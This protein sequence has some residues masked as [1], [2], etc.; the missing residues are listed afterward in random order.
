MKTLGAICSNRSTTLR[1]PKSGEQHDQIAPTL[2]DARRPTTAS[3]RFGR[4]AATLSPGFTPSSLKYAARD[5]VSALSS[6]HVTWESSSP[7]PAEIRATSSS[8][9]FLN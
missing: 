7:S 4:Y 1:A 3:G 5:A 9:L 8:Y 2:A 6:P